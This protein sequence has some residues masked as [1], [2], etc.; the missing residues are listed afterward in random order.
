MDLS[1]CIVAQINIS[2]YV[3]LFTDPIATQGTQVSM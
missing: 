3:E 1:I 2:P